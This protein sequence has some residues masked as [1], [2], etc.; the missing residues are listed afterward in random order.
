MARKKKQY[1]QSMTLPFSGAAN[2]A[3]LTDGLRDLV[4]GLFGKRKAYLP[5]QQEIA[6]YYLTAREREIA[7]LAALGFTHQEIA[8]A[9]GMN[10]QTVRVHLRNV[11]NK[12]QLAEAQEL[13]D[14][15]AKR[16]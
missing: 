10:F 9:L 3:S 15:F 1:E 14:Y 4:N 11:L 12:M 13:R 8:D 16:S 7:Y 5:T 2:S 6:D